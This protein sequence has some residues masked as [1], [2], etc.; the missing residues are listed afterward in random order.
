MHRGERG[1][2]AAYRRAIRALPWPA[3]QLAGTPLTEPIAPGAFPAFKADVETRV[4]N[5]NITV[6][7]AINASQSGIPVACGRIVEAVTRNEPAVVPPGCHRPEYGVTLSLPVV[8]GREDVVHV[9][10]PRMSEEERAALEPSVAP[11]H[12]AIASLQG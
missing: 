12:P 11:M 6:I 4:R 5:P 2:R 7:A 8:S 9:V 10:R 3:A 1:R